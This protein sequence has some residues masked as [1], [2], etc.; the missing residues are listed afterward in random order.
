MTISVCRWCRSRSA[1]W[2]VG[3]AGLISGSPPSKP[4][5]TQSRP[6]P[7]HLP[8]LVD[9]EL[10][11]YHGAPLFEASVHGKASRQSFTRC[12][13]IGGEMTPKHSFL[14]DRRTRFLDVSE[15]HDER[16]LCGF[17]RNGC[18]TSTRIVTKNVGPKTL[19]DFRN[20]YC[21]LTSS[22]LSSTFFEVC[23]RQSS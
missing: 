17:V 16:V 11:R 12:D 23:W 18:G 14:G 7:L 5:L 8:Y 6:W 15:Q 10:H 19:L 2:D 21:S 4:T 20:P 9:V 22:D 13:L 3:R 1:H